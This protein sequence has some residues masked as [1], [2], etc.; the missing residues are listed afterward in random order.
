MI[1]GAYT[2]LDFTQYE[3]ENSVRL[4]YSTAYVANVTFKAQLQTQ[5][6]LSDY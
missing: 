5:Q 4:D 1:N 2:I 3:K 6:P